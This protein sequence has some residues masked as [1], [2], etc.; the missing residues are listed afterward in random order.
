MGFAIPVDTVNRV[1]AQLI[2]HGRVVRPHLG[3]SVGNAQALKRAGIQGVLIMSVAEGSPAQRAGL[4]GT[5]RA[6]DGSLVLGDI[7]QEIDGR[8]VSS[9]DDV[10]AALERHRPGDVVKV[11]I[12]RDGQPREIEVTLAAPRE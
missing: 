4:R 3:I 10:Y 1:A 12:L 11:G 2:A 5:Y 6:G 9:V 8:T 7:V